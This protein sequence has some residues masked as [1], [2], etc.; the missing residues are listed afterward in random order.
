MIRQTPVLSLDPWRRFIVAFITAACMAV[1]VATWLPSS[2]RAETQT[3]NCPGAKIGGIKWHDV[4]GDLQQN[5]AEE[6]LSGFTIQLSTN[7]GKPPTTATTDETGYYCFDVSPGVYTVAEV[8]DPNTQAD[9]EQTFPV[10]GVET[11]TIEA[12]TVPSVTVNFGNKK[13]PNLAINKVRVTDPVVYGQPVTYTLAVSNAGP[14]LALG[15]IIVTDNMGA[16]PLLTTPVTASAAAPWACSVTG[17]TVQCSHPGPLPVNASLPVITV[18]AQV[19]ATPPVPPMILG[20]CATVAV[21]NDL[22]LQ[23]NRDCDETDKF[24][25]PPRPDLSLTKS[26]KPTFFTVGQQGQWIITVTNIGAGPTTGVITVTDTI[27][28]PLTPVS[29]SGAGWTCNLVGATFTCTHPGPLAPST[30][31][32]PITITVN[33][34]GGAVIAD[35]CADTS[36]PG[37]PGVS[38]DGTPTNNH[39]CDHVDIQQQA[40]LPDL[41]IKKALSG[42]LTAGQPGTFALTVGNAGPGPT[43]NTIVVTDTLPL[44][45]TP[46]TAGGLGWSCTITG[47]QVV[48]THPGPLAVGNTLPPLSITALVAP[49]LAVIDNCALVN[50]VGDPN[51]VN[52]RNCITANVAPHPLPPDVT[53]HKAIATPLIGGG[54]GTFSLTVSNIGPGPTTGAIVVTDT[55][56][57]YLTAPVV[58]APVPWSCTVSGQQIVCTHPGPLTSGQSLPT[59]MITVNVAAGIQQAAN[60]ASVNTVGDAKPRNNRGCVSGP[61]GTGQKPDLTIKKAISGPLIAGQTA[62]FSITVSNLGP[63]ATTGPITV[64]DNLIFALQPPITA[65]GAGWSCS[66]VG[67]LVTCTHPGPLPAGQALPP[68]FITA[69]IKPGAQVVENCAKVG[70]AGDLNPQNNYTCIGGPVKPAG[71]PDLAIKK[72]VIGDIVSGQ[73]GI[74]LLNVANIGTG[75]TTGPIVVVDS[76]PAGLTPLGAFAPPP[77]SCGISGQVVTCIHPGP[78][79]AGNSLPPI[80]IVVQ[81]NLPPGKNVVNC[82]IVKTPGDANLNNN[83]G[84][85]N[86]KPD[87]DHDLVADELECPTGLLVCADSDRDG[88]LDYLDEDDDGDGVPSA[89]ELGPDGT[90]QD[91]DGDGKSDQLDACSLKSGGCKEDVY[92]WK[93]K[94]RYGADSQ[95][96]SNGGLDLCSTCAAELTQEQPC[97]GCDSPHGVALSKSV[98]DQPEL[99][100]LAGIQARLRLRVIGPDMEPDL[101]TILIEADLD[102]DGTFEPLSSLTLQP[103]GT[104]GLVQLVGDFAGVGATLVDVEVWN[105]GQFV[106]KVTV[107]AGVLGSFDGGGAL[108]SLTSLPPGQPVRTAFTLGFE[109]SFHF[110][111]STV[112]AAQVAA[113]LTGN[114]FRITAANPTKPVTS[115]D[116]VT[117][118]TDGASLTIESVDAAGGVLYLPLVMR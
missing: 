100:H 41:A 8:L 7:D 76:L 62:T 101:S 68:I 115:F 55:L 29:A 75:P 97:A 72:K 64:V 53:I 15:P 61:V 113:P 104:P 17:M 106:A 81:V 12:G 96:N 71:K 54:T 99:Q 112:A 16:S 78:L 50:T 69:S 5:A 109:S 57:A 39:G 32:P 77:W 70:T 18:V 73:I 24:Q 21:K 98:N 66:V 9:W 20:N 25:L 38:S 63:G 105:N 86:V 43:T 83:R 35:N 1:V 108:L 51:P 107:P 93:I 2:A 6:V 28:P 46:L 44:G 59:I 60:C 88:L 33:V 4:N 45:L 49:G 118:L 42:T 23:N 30:S 52:D 31:L 116:Q 37:D 14:G 67:L 65:T 92:V 85:T 102:G 10:T 58:S 11:V 111:P 56:P 82:A 47:Q 48:C 110:T 3:F 91:V 13:K 34:G 40:L 22:N 90:L 94:P 80:V 103:S 117:I 114:E 84:C 87:F 26:H 89:S 36:T 95:L 79:A 74:F 19:V 27:N